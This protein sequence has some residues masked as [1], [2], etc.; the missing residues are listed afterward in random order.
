MS[1]RI[2]SMINQNQR[3]ALYAFGM[4][5]RVGTICNLEVISHLIVGEKDAAM[6]RSLATA[7]WSVPDEEWKEDFYA[8]KIRKERIMTQLVLDYQAETGDIMTARPWK[9]LAKTMLMGKFATLDVVGTQTAL[10]QLEYLTVEPMLKDV[11]RELLGDIENNDINDLTYE[12][13][14]KAGEKRADFCFPDDNE[15][16]AEITKED[17]NGKAQ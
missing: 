7:L 12:E 1:M 2:N 8:I 15:V 6:L 17:A 3:N 9:P 16:Y 11:I 13:A 14:L 4:P 10:M 5:S